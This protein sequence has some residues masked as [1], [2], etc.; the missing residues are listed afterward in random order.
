ME[1]G[2]RVNRESV[3]SKVMEKYMKSIKKILKYLMALVAV[4]CY[5]TAASVLTSCSDDNTVT[6]GSATGKQEETMADY[7]VIFWGMA[8]GNDRSTSYDLA[9]L[10]YRY[11]KGNIG[12]NV[13]IAGLIKTSMSKESPGEVD[14]SYDK[15]MYFDSETIGSDQIKVSDFGSSSSVYLYKKAFDTMGGKEYGDTLYP[16]SNVDS[17]AGFIKK[18]AQKFPARHYVLMLLGHGNGFSPLNDTPLT[19]ACVYDEFCQRRVLSADAVVSA[20][21]KS[22]VKMQTLFTQCCLMATLENIAAYSQ[23][24]DYG[25]LSAETTTGGYL[26]KYLANLSTAGDDE[27]KMQQESRNLVDYYVDN[28]SSLYTTSH[29]FY[30][31]RKASALLSATKDAANWFIDNYAEEKQQNAIGNALCSSIISIQLEEWKDQRRTDSLRQARQRIQD[32][33]SGK[34]SLWDME[35]DGFITYINDVIWL[36]NQYS[37]ATSFCMA[38]VLRN[39]V[40][41]NLPQDKSAEIKEI[42][43]R[44]MTALKDM[45]YIRATKK[46]ASADADYEYI[47]ASPTVN[48]FSMHPDYFIF[49]SKEKKKELY[50]L[51]M[52]FLLDETSD[53]GIDEFFDAVHQLTDV[54]Y[55]AYCSDLATVKANYTSSVFDKQ[56]GWSKFLEQLHQNPSLATCPDRWQVNQK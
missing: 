24:F 46:P 27:T 15:T 10:A 52:K 5:A 8:G 49:P 23:V 31:L 33:L 17:L 51:M 2:A 14:P 53:I 47:Y 35:D 22:G 29:G 19:R 30:D 20:V 4:L 40:A 7:T 13:Q 37:D 26:Q 43:E 42:Y 3:K 16:L 36:T 48:I 18:A 6:D 39:A 44:Y 11:Q 9:N 38:D 28:I 56:V 34:T 12:K 45:A 55:Y 41:A 32:V 21:E 54:T 1:V 25:I 50:N